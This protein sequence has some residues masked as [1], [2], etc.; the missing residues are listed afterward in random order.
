MIELPPL[1]E[2]AMCQ[3]FAVL[4]ATASE[5]A[6]KVRI[7]DCYPPN[8]IRVEGGVFVEFRSGGGEVYALAHDG[9][10]L[11]WARVSNPAVQQSEAFLAYHWMRHLG[12]VVGSVRETEQDVS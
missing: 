7:M 3:S 9:C 12:V 8:I 4:E 1:W 5:H 10:H 2:F 11:W 6:I